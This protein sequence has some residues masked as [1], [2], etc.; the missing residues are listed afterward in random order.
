MQFLWCSLNLK[1]LSLTIAEPQRSLEL[2]NGVE[3]GPVTC[4]WSHLERFYRHSSS[5]GVLFDFRIAFVLFV[6]TSVCTRRLVAIMKIL[7]MG[8]E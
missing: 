7:K 3:K 8:R 6:R 4:I 1:N 2:G 5:H